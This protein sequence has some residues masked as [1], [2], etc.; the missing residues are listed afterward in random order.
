MTV[1]GREEREEVAEGEEKTCF[2]RR[3]VERSACVPPQSETN[4]RVSTESL[5]ERKGR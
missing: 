1:I 2:F 5:E 3:D 4:K